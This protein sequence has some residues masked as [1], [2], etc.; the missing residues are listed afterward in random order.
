M[1]ENTKR[2]LSNMELIYDNQPLERD[3]AKQ[4]RFRKA[5]IVFIYLPFS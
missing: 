5:F 1:C 4:C 2:I 3:R